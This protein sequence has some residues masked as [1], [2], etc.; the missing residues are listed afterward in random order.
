METKDELQYYID[1]SR[2][3]YFIKKNIPKDKSKVS[4]INSNVIFN[5]DN[6][7]IIEL[8]KN[9]TDRLGFEMLKL[10]TSIYNDHSVGS[11]NDVYNLLLSYRDAFNNTLFKKKTFSFIDIT[12]PTELKKYYF[13]NRLADVNTTLLHQ[14]ANECY[15]KLFS[16]DYNERWRMFSIRDHES[17]YIRTKEGMGSASNDF[18]NKEDNRFKMRIPL[19]P[20][21][22]NEINIRI[23]FYYF[24]MACIIFPKLEIY[25]K[26]D[27]NSDNRQCGKIFDFFIYSVEYLYPFIC[28]TMK[29]IFYILNMN[30]ITGE[31]CMMKYPSH[32]LAYIHDNTYI[33]KLNDD[34]QKDFKTTIDLLPDGKL[35]YCKFEYKIFQIGSLEFSGRIDSHETLNALLDNRDISIDYGKILEANKNSTDI[36]VLNAINEIYKQNYELTEKEISNNLTL[37]TKYRE[38]GIDLAFNQSDTVLFQLLQLH[39][40][41]NNYR[42]IYSSSP[43][44]GIFKYN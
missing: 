2:S 30:N 15:N 20:T 4:V 3:L 39:K 6:D 18:D 35:I 31:N 12:L 22:L 16:K 27:T 7:V 33:E 23:I 13:L 11:Q 40:S 5:F 38:I 37:D 28:I 1:F 25:G 42:F 41:I 17:D 21:D 34:F 24:F 8:I 44:T 32:V 36:E 10:V 14:K 29:D 19:N 43:A 26:M 9:M